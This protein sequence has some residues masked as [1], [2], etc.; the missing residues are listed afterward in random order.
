MDPIGTRLKAAREARRLS[1]RDVATATKMSVTTLEALE[2]SDFAR[3][4]GGIYA[5][6]FVRA[7]AA[8]LD[9]APDE[10]VDAYGVELAQ[11]QRDAARKQAK[12]KVTAGDREFLAKQ[13]R[14]MR[15]LRVGIVLA[16]LLVLAAIA[17]AIWTMTCCAPPESSGPGARGP[18]RHHSSPLASAR[19][20]LSG[21][22][23]RHNQTG[24]SVRS[25]A[26]FEA[27]RPA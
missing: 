2:R 13:E 21:D 3:L 5:R 7:Y 14:A 22:P 1:L 15:L 10:M 11:H 24:V 17:W 8:L 6:S 9:L 18:A 12:P 23:V 26:V 27:R 19:T 20:G 25:A 4:P 16:G